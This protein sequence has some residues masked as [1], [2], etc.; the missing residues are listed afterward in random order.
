MKT[1]GPVAQRARAHAKLLVLGVL[2]FMGIV[3]LW[4]PLQFDRIAER[5]YGKTK[6]R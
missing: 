2:G 4:T 6:K 1:E 5:W 3:S